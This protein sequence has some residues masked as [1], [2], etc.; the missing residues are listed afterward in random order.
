M[1][2]VASLPCLEYIVGLVGVNHSISPAV[3]PSQSTQLASVVFGS[4]I[5][6]ASNVVPGSRVN[7]DAT[8][9]INGVGMAEDN[10]A[11]GIGVLLPRVHSVA[12]AVNE[13]EVA[14]LVNPTD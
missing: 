12:V 7:G 4:F 6:K 5:A 13:R 2:L 10:I 3:L 9:I 14:A 11:V 8:E 1:E